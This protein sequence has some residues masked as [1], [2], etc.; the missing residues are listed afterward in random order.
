MPEVT[1]GEPDWSK[2][3]DWRIGP[4]GGKRVNEVDR[5]AGEALQ[6]WLNKRGKGKAEEEE[7]FNFEDLDDEPLLEDE[8]SVRA[9]GSLEELPD[10]IEED[11][12]AQMDFMEDDREEEM[13]QDVK[14]SL[15]NSTLEP[16]VDEDSGD[17]L[18]KEEALEEKTSTSRNTLFETTIASIVSKSPS[19]S[20]QASSKPSTSSN[21]LNKA[22]ESYTSTQR[23]SGRLLVLVGT[24]TI[25]KEKIVKACAQALG[26]K[27]FCQDPRKYKTYT[28]IDDPEL[29]DLLTRNPRAGVHVTNLHAINGETLKNMFSAL[30]SRG[31]GF[32][33][34][35]A[36]RPTGWSYKPT[37]GLETMA[38]HDIWK[39]IRWNQGMDYEAKE[40]I[41]T[42]DSDKNFRIYGVPYSEH[43]SFVSFLSK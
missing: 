30:N 31:H 11:D 18:P 1:T 38:A 8:D 15:M 32:T 2:D 39:L 20:K 6:G 17:A 3:E 4:T 28:Q 23:P 42:R 40:F 16:E 12:S 5:K 13:D 26:T 22:T 37:N 21:W 33:H 9:D 10:G 7:D 25:G 14:P 36:L 34:A 35:I 41:Q 24:Y 27:V 29:H 43:S 19:K